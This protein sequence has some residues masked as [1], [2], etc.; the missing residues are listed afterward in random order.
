MNS[1]KE[2]YHNFIKF[3]NNLD[4]ENDF[5]KD[6]QNMDAYIFILALKKRMNDLG[7]NK[8]CKEDAITESYIRIIEKCNIDQDKFSEEDISKFK[9]YLDYFYEIAKIMN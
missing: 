9:R 4:P 1:L 3:I 2:K 7:I 8:M 5:I 6:F